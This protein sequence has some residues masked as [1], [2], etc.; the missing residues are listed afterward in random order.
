MKF[1]LCLALMGCV[2]PRQSFD[3]TACA[4]TQDSVIA[5]Q[6]PASALKRFTAYVRAQEAIV[7]TNLTAR[8][9][10]LTGHVEEAERQTRELI[11]GGWWVEGYSYMVYCRRAWK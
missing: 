2:A 4:S 5:G 8:H 3:S 1:L 6:L 9:E 7:P 11:K 10:Y